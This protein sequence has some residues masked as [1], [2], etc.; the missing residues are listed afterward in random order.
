MSKRRTRFEVTVQILDAITEPMIITHIMRACR[1][2]VATAR[3]I[4]EELIARGLVEKKVQTFLCT[5]AVSGRRLLSS[6]PKT[7]ERTSYLR[8]EKG[9][10]FLKHYRHL[11]ELFHMQVVDLSREYPTTR[12]KKCPVCLADP[13]VAC[14]RGVDARCLE[15]G[16]EFCGR[17][18]GEH[19][20]KAHQIS[21]TWRGHLREVE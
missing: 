1:C 20:E 4:L 18:I 15:C 17:H 16:E 7:Y 10:L 6:K 5:S 2:T 13:E 19:L 14:P 3:S 8:T 21:L 9:R 12:L 11:Q